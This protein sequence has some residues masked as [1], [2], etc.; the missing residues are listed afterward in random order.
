MEIKSKKS[1]NFFSYFKRG[2]IFILNI[3]SSKKSK[4]FFKIIFII[5]FLLTGFFSGLLLSGYF[6]TL[7]NPSQEALDI[8]HSWG[9]SDLR[10]VKIAIESIL[11]ENIKIPFNYLKGQFSKPEKIY[12]D[13]DFENYQKL[14]YQRQQALDRGEIITSGEDFVP[15]KITHKGNEINVR[16]RLKG[17]AVSHLEGDKWSFR[18]KVKD[19]KTLFGMKTFS[20]QDPRERNYLSE[21]VYH[22]ALKREEIIGLRYDFIEVVINGENKGI[23]AIEEHFEKQLIES[24]NR[25]EGVILKLETDLINDEQRRDNLAFSNVLERTEY[26]QKKNPDLFYVRNIQTFDDEDILLDP[27]LSKQFKQAKNLLDLFRE[28]KLQTHEVFDIDK[29]A[30]YFAINTLLSTEHASGRSNIRFY[31]NPITSHIEPIGYDAGGRLVTSYEILENYYIPNCFS[32]NC[33]QKDVF[34]QLIFQDKVFFEKYIKELERVSEK[35]YLESLFLELDNDLKNNIN[36]I[37]KNKPTYHFSTEFYYLNSQQIRNKLNPI[38]G[39]NVY[40]QKFL[41]SENKIILSI[42]NNDFMPLEIVN[43]VYND[44]IILEL[45]QANN[46]L[47]PKPYLEPVVYNE[48]EFKIPSNLNLNDNFISN[49]KVNYKVF[50]A[51]NIYLLDV[52]P[53]SYVEEDFIEEDF[54][55]QDS[56]LTFFEFLNINYNTKSIS[57]KQGDWILNKDLIIPEEFT[58]FI[59]EGTQIDQINDAT[60]LSYSNLQ[61]LGTSENPIRITSS[62][63]SGQGISVL[64]ADKISNVNHVIFENLNNPMKSG[65]DLTGAINFYKSKVKLNNVVIKNINSEDC[66]N[67]IDSEFEIK[68]SQ[69]QNCFSDCF[70]NDFGKGTIEG[71]SF[72][73][74]GNDALDFSGTTVSVKNVNI[75]GAKDKAISVGEISNLSI[76]NVNIF[77]DTLNSTY[78]GIASKDNSQVVIKN[79]QFSNV[80][81]GFA[82][83]QKKSE[84]G[85]AK[86][87]SSNTSILNTSKNHIIEKNSELSIDG[88]IVLSNEEDVYFKLYRDSE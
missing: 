60:I 31:Y 10:D 38:H 15:A 1:D 81:Y 6:G 35:S 34:Y 32:N 87:T 23:Y 52:L 25:R 54:I 19:D 55:R 20:I 36:I 47:E 63:K 39:L 56:N 75:F 4:I 45:N 61:F 78:I 73:I 17:I 62:D 42:G 27:I 33:S 29:L 88:A 58:F 84:Y 24:N 44:S 11:A 50:G 80:Q 21:F 71:T 64:N 72:N 46:F 8:L 85:P 16:L 12:I 65:W 41:P 77:G 74:C 59:E 26:S 22:Q 5:F 53:Y 69:F 40:S 68:N 76:E 49:L 48:F 86:I 30:T 2:S 28:E 3:I 51:K 67:I 70:D 57:V 43:L 9:F 14:E 13:I 37:H 66:L 79:S 7:D 18:I 82:V 83:Y